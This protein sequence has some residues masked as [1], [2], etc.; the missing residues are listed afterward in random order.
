MTAHSWVPDLFGRARAQDPFNTLRS[1]IDRVFEGFPRRMAGA[2]AMDPT[3]DVA[4]TED[5][6]RITIELP[7]V[8]R[9]D[10]DISL[11]NNLLTI[12]GEKKSESEEKGETLHRVERSYGAFQRVLSAPPGIDP[13]KVTAA[14]KDGVLH[15]TL[16]KAPEAKAAARRIA[17]DAA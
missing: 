9:E 15:V 13:A 4:E 17:I 1:E 16:P 11:A 12:K 2:E 5:E 6:I 3:L 7:G 10:V 8:K 14:M